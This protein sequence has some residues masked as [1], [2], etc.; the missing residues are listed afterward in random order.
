MAYDRCDSYQGSSTRFRSG[1][2]QPRYGTYKRGLN[3]KVHL[4]VAKNGLPVGCIVTAGTI[5][6]CTK[7]VDLLQGLIADTLFA[8]RAY[9]TNEIIEYAKTR[10]ME[11]V[12]PP[13]KNRVVQRE[14]NKELYKLRHLVEN[15]ILKVKRWRGIATR[16][17]KHT[18]SFL[19]SV[20]ACCVF[21]W[22]KYLV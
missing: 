13:K 4:A 17:A 20:C 11:I 22:A 10:N 21:L 12:I 18:A 16:Y 1:R 7:A 3:S 6:D 8:D 19:A 14:Y 5:G 2:R 9:D 15:A